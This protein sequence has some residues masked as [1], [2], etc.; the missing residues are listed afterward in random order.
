MAE[1][2]SLGNPEALARSQ[3]IRRRNV[4][5]GFKKGKDRCIPMPFV[6]CKVLEQI[7]AQY[8]YADLDRN[9]A[10]VVTVKSD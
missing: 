3:K 5:F 2:Q 4:V 6:L 10:R 9:A 7:I 8:I 1:L